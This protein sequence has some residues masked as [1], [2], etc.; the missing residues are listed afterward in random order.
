MFINANTPIA[1]AQLML[2]GNGLGRAVVIDSNGLVVGFVSLR[3]VGR[4]R[5][6]QPQ[7]G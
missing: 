3:D 4:A 7:P 2:T 1:Q 6:E 5:G